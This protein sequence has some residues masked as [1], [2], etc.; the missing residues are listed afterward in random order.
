MPP[1]EKEKPGPTPGTGPLGESVSDTDKDQI[2]CRC[3]VGEL[4]AC[5]F[6][7]D[8]VLWWPD[9]PQDINSR[10]RRRQAANRRLIP[11]ADIARRCA[12]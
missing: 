1:P 5:P 2:T 9:S 11:L 4:C 12:A 8:W 10:I 7:A 6:Y 3:G